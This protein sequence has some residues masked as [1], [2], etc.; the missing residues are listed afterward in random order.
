MSE[1]EMQFTKS[2]CNFLAKEYYIL[3]SK[4]ISRRIYIKDLFAIKISKTLVEEKRD[5]IN[6]INFNFI[7]K[8]KNITL[9]YI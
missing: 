6:L 4:N 5:I 1:N 7:R 9:S 2:A 3:I 8:N